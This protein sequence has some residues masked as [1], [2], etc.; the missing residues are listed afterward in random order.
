MTACDPKRSFQ[1]IYLSANM[2]FRNHLSN[3]RSAIVQLFSQVFSDSEGE[4][5]G[6]SIE[7]L[8]VNLFETSDD[9]DLYNFVADDSGQL[10]GSIFLTRLTLE[11]SG[12]VF[13]MAPVAVHSDFQGQGV[14]QALIE[15]GLGELKHV[16]VRFVVTYGDP[17]F[18]SKVGFRHI[19]DEAVR[20]PFQLSQPEGWLGLSLTGSPIQDFAGSCACVPAFRDAAYW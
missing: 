15:F 4:A 14:G 13:M 7:K 5:E 8:T 6:A 18:Y 20:P 10:I 17:A 3:D 12:E 2:L 9:R 16:G 1:S 19:S 11:G